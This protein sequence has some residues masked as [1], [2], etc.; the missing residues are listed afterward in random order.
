MAIFLV[1]QGQTYKYEREGGYIWSP[2]LN[3]AGQRNRGYDMMKE[4]RRGDY[5]LHNSGGRIAAISVVKEDCKSGRQPRELKTA[6]SIYE[7]DDDG[8]VVY[9]KYYDFD[10]PILTSNLQEWAQE[11]YTKDS[12]FQINGKLLLRYLCNLSISHAEYIIQMAIR[13]QEDERVIRVLRAALFSLNPTPKTDEELAEEMGLGELERTAAERSKK[14]VE[15]KEVITKQY[16]RDPYISELAKRLANG[17]CELCG[18]PAPFKDS[19][20]KPYLETH[21]VVWLSQ[22]GSDS[23]DNTVALCPNCHRKMHIVADSGDVGVLKR[24]AKNNAL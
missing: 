23:V 10:N 19:K 1:N 15:Q 22:G 21:H 13:L 17:K 18:K 3:K 16:S 2:K 20:G 7:W 12:A 6:N 5:I 24:V 4:V 8:W 11:N 9:T 14:K